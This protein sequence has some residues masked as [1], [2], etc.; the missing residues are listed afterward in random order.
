MIQ[1]YSFVADGD[2]KGQPRVKATKVGGFVRVYTPGTANDFK[3]SI[4]EAATKAGLRGKLMTGP[5]RVTIETFFAR[6]KSHFRGGKNAGVL[7][8]SAPEWHTT[9]PDRDNVEKACLD[10]LTAIGVWKDDS[11][12]CDGPVTKKYTDS[13]PQTRIKIECL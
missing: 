1:Q 6:P 5:L 11:Q 12:V 8:D 13:F 4:K 9:K 7:R 3:A 2:P 10:A